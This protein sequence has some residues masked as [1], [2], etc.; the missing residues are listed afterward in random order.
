MEH[1]LCYVA[2]DQCFQIALDL[3]KF[4][5]SAAAKKKEDEAKVNPPSAPSAASEEAPAAGE[6]APT[7]AAEEA[8]AAPV[9]EEPAAAPAAEE[10]APAAEAA[11]AVEA[12][13]AEAA[14]AAEEVSRE[15]PA[16]I[17]I[18]QPL[19][20]SE[21]NPQPQI[22]EF[23]RPRSR[24]DTGEELEFTP[25]ADLTF[26]N[27]TKNA[28]GIYVAKEDTETQAGRDAM[29]LM[30]TDHMSMMLQND[31]VYFQ[32]RAQVPPVS[33]MPSPGPQGAYGFTLATRLAR[34][35][36]RGRSM[37]DTQ[38]KN[39][40][41]DAFELQKTTGK[42]IHHTYVGGGNHDKVQE[43]DCSLDFV[44]WLASQSDQS[45]MQHI[46]KGSP[47]VMTRARIENFLQQGNTHSLLGEKLQ[48]EDFQ[49][50]HSSY[51][52][53]EQPFQ[54]T[55]GEGS[56]AASFEDQK[57][58]EIAKQG[59]GEPLQVYRQLA[60]DYAQ[61]KRARGFVAEQ[62]EVWDEQQRM[63]VTAPHPEG[64]AL[65]GSTD[66]YV[67]AMEGKIWDSIAQEYVAADKAVISTPPWFM[68]AQIDPSTHPD[69]F[70]QTLVQQR[71]TNAPLTASAVEAG[72]YRWDA[73]HLQYVNAVGK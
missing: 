39:F 61:Q 58:K 33:A 35:L 11:P 50:V 46:P 13:P 14:P 7:P 22:E 43:F 32:P 34:E 69:M 20:P 53:S 26:K 9:A 48:R 31:H 42:I 65:P 24:F 73:E 18:N 52:R 49:R 68:Q 29:Q 5:K 44:Q 12:A 57:Q 55:G 45:M 66:Y 51:L 47:N 40:T 36:T 17:D 30:E 15:S 64:A 16:P 67:A 37:V 71:P 2:C 10:A 56:E 27:Y 4:A 28:Q 6:A 70:N 54:Y 62:R 19:V 21:A 8:A 63:F 38:D 72:K 3:P 25:A 60:G 23:A 41:G 59:M 1:L